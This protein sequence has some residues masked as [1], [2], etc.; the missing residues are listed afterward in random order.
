MSSLSST[1]MMVGLT[2]GNM[3]LIFCFLLLD[4]NLIS[5]SSSCFLLSFKGFFPGII[6]MLRI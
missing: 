3:A 5:E 1:W 6:S 2:G 4:T